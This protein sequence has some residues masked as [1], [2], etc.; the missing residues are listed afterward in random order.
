MAN[1]IYIKK[2]PNRRLYNTNTSSYITISDVADLIKQGFRVQVT[3]V[4]TDYD[5]TA[6]VLTQII[7]DK[8]KKN[9]ELLPVSLLHL[10]IQ[11]G[12][13]LLHDFFD[14]YLEKTMES[15]LVY[16]K[17]M[18]DQVNAY[19]DMGMDFSSLAEKTLRDIEAMN[20]FSES[21]KNFTRKK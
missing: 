13:N 1:I 5:V 21:Y 10:V 12:E 7:M 2:Y 17:N 16:R 8:A 15:Y 11:F 18:D 14:K 6:L 3:D 9:Q 4:T 19:L 20:V